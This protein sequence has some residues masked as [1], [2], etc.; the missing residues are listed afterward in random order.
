MQTTSVPSRNIIGIYVRTTNEN[1]QSAVDIPQLWNKFLSENLS[2]K[3]PNKTSDTLFCIYTDYES[4]FT[5][6][7]TTILG[8]EVS[9]LETIP[10]GFTSTTIKAGDYLH[11][12]A[13]GKLSDNIVFS[14]WQKIWSSNIPR[15]Y[16]SDFEV[17]NEKSQDPENAEVEIFISTK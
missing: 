6:P 14:E 10:E 9:S 5:K 13:K 2:S 15:T 12:L 1:G 7:Y 16:E 17:Y 11:F 3:I 4:D 8:C